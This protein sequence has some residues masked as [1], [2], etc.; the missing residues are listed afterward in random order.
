MGGQLDHL[1]VE[2][3]R[4]GSLPTT[5][6]SQGA[7]MGLFGGLMGWEA[8][9]ARLPGSPQALHESGVRIASR[10]WMRAMSIRIPTA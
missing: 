8:D 3:D 6:E 7:D 5:H 1:L 10:R 9:D 4:N 2:F